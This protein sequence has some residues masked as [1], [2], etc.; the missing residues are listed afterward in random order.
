[1]RRLLVLPVALLA[2]IALSAGPAAAATE[3]FT[4]RSTAPLTTTDPGP[5]AFSGTNICDP[6]GLD[7][8]AEVTLTFKRIVV[9]GT[10][11]AGPPTE[12]QF[13]CNG[14]TQEW[15]ADGVGPFIRNESIL[16]DTIVLW[17]DGTTTVRNNLKVKIV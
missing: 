13:V 7:T 12:T 14:T 1:M 3:N 5:A 10:V 4:L 16:V 17:P 2:V 6:V 11:P 9:G 8:T 15:S